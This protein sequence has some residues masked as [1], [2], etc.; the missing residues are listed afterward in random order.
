M[1]SGVQSGVQ[2]GAKFTS[3]DSAVK[4]HEDIS[5]FTTWKDIKLSNE[6]GLLETPK[7]VL[8]FL[9]VRET[10]S[11]VFIYNIKVSVKLETNFN[12]D[13]CSNTEHA[14]SK[15]H[16]QCFFLRKRFLSSIRYSASTHRIA[17]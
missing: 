4:K 6:G 12:L 11:C 7:S 14:S 17:N 9:A 13:Q 2:Y 10:I 15:G 3:I 1:R 5:Y 16:L 8:S